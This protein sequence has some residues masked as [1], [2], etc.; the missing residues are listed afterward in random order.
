MFD[1]DVNVSVDETSITALLFLSNSLERSTDCVLERV[2]YAI[3]DPSPLLL[4]LLPDIDFLAPCCCR[5]KLAVVVLFELVVSDDEVYEDEV[6]LEKFLRRRFVLLFTCC[7]EALSPSSLS[8][9]VVLFEFRRI[10]KS[11]FLGT[12]FLVPPLLLLRAV[13]AGAVVDGACV[14]KSMKKYNILELINFME[15]K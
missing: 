12:R 6:E 8:S 3:E 1:D 9:S 10:F 15:V 13:T 4:L 5:R 7:D 11:R 2:R 14:D